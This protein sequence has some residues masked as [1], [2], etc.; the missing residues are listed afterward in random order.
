MYT[1]IF[2]FIYLIINTK[3]LKNKDILKK[4]IF[5]LL[6]ILTL[7]S[8]FWMP[9]LEHKNATQYEVF[10]EGRMERTNVLVAFKL[11]FD[12]LFITKFDSL[13]IYEIGIITLIGLVITPIVIKKI[14]EIKYNKTDF[15][16]LY[17][18]LLV[19][20]II[21]LIMTLKIFPFEHLPSTLK[22][23]QF[24]FRMLEFSSFFLSFVVAINFG[25]M[26][27]N[28]K[29]RDTVIIT[30]LLMILTS[31][32]F[33][34]IQYIDNY[35]ESKLWTAVR[36]TE[37]TGRV[38]AGCASF[39]YL[40]SKAFENL[41]YI[42]TRNQEVNIIQGTAQIE[43]ENKQNTNMT[44]DIKY[45]LEDTKLELP[46][47]YYLGYDV[48]L[49]V[50]NTKKKLET[51]ET[52]NGFIGVTVP[53]LENAKIVVKYEGTNIMKISA[54]VSIITLIICVGFSIRKKMK[55]YK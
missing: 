33:S 24:S 38:H 14:K 10:K 32:F 5:S 23:M 45:V 9:L 53:V 19:S 21:S 16:K 55:L 49:E 11:D 37:N 12:Q 26:I 6:I 41:D 48:T 17:I 4:I 50:N 51:Y 8:F 20:G 2:A 18:F 42:K 34:H 31:L 44:F 25:I 35:D 22:M 52:E 40:P 1:A 47:I 46:Y 7:T 54:F 29:E 43:N 30:I 13:M 36:V 27:K 3:K 15:Y 28:I 39:E